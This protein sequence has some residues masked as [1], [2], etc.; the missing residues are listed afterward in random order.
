MFFPRCLCGRNCGREWEANN[1]GNN[2]MQLKQVNGVSNCNSQISNSPGAGYG[3]SD[4]RRLSHAAL[5]RSRSI[6][7]NPTESCRRDVTFQESYGNSLLP[8]RNSRLTA[9]CVSN[10]IE[11]K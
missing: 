1:K 10:H 4:G 9:S 5:A 6:S 7:I 11:A 2:T 8:Q 3:H